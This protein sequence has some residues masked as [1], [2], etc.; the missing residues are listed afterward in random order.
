MK[1][2]AVS[3][4][5]GQP[6]STLMLAER[7]AEATGADEVQQV[8]LRLVAHDLVNALLTRVQS[9]ALEQIVDAV[10]EA[11]GIVA[12]SP[13]Y[14]GGVSGLFKLFFDVLH[15]GALID[16]PVLLAATGGTPRHSLAIERGMLPMFFYLKAALV[17]T[18]VFAATDDW[19]GDDNGLM[20]RIAQAGEELAA[21][22]RIRSGKAAPDALVEVDETGPEAH[23]DEHREQRERPAAQAVSGD[24]TL[25]RS[26]EEMFGDI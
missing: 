17:P 9:P 13:I 2:L 19:A 22:V 1:I 24:L 20:R 25:T 26:F 14:N 7:L 16:K 3:A 23:A 4:G 21:M 5:A 6:S 8:E 15:E 10:V 11:D 18:S 12:V